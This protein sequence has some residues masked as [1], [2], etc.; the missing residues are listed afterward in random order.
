MGFCCCCIEVIILIVVS[1]F[2][3]CVG[4]IFRVWLRRTISRA[5]RLICCEFLV[6]EG[7]L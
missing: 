5:L 3:K 4:W 2:W 6:M 7:M 1:L